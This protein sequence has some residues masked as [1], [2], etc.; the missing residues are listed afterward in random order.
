MGKVAVVKT[1]PSNVLDDYKKVMNLADYQKF[2]S[3]KNETIL[4]LNLSWSLYYPA[5]ST[6]PW[7]LEGVLRTMLEEGYKHLHAVE[8]ETVVTDVWKGAKGN[9]WLDVLKRYKQKYEPLTDKKWVHYEPKAEM[10]A[11]DEIFPEGNKIPECFIGKNVVQFPTVKCVHPETEIFM[12]DGSLVKIGEFIEALGEEKGFEKDIDGDYFINENK[13]VFSLEESKIVSYKVD[14]FWKTPSPKNLIYIK[15]KLGKEVKVS[16]KHPF[17]T[18]KGWKKSEEIQVGDRIAVPRLVKFKGRSQ[19][20]PKIEI[21]G[22]DLLDINKIKFRNGKKH[23]KELQKEIVKDY[24]VKEKTITIIGKE[25]KLNPETIRNIIKRYGFKMRWVRNWVNVPEKTSLEFWKWLGYFVAEGYAYSCSGSMRFS[26]NNGNSEVVKD[27]VSLTKNLFNVD[28]KVRKFENKL[29]ILYFDS[30]NIVSFFEELGFSFPMVAGNKFAPKILLKCPEKEIISFLEG[31]LDGDGTVGKDG[32]H[33]TSKSK[34]LIKNIQIL[35]LRLGVIGLIKETWC[36]ATNGKMKEKELYY[37]L[38]V[39]GHDLVIFGNIINLKSENKQKNLLQL[40]KRRKRSKKLTNWDTIPIDRKMF[41]KVR[42]GLDF[43][44]NT[45]KKPHSVNSIE[46]GYSLPTR[47]TMNY[48]L[49]LF[50]KTNVDQS[51]LIERERMRFLSS[52]KLAWDHIEEIKEVKSDVDWLY[53]LT[54]LGVENFIGNG[55]IL[56]NTHGH[57]Q[58]TGAMKNAFG[59]LITKKRHHCHKNIHE[60]LVDLLAIQKEIHPGRFAVMD[61]TVCGDGAGP[62]TMSPKVKNYILAS[63]D[64]VAIDAI[65]AKM[66]GYDPMKIK[67]IKLAHDRGLGMGDVDQIDI[68]GEDISKVNF[69][70]STSKSP[71]IFWDQMFRKGALSFVEPLLFHTGLFKGPVFAS[72]FYHDKIWYPTVGKSR[73]RKFMKTDWGQLWKKY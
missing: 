57:T 63:E 36:I 55:I 56:H 24:V 60:V 73:I 25:R 31:Y 29:D 3:K 62:R 45:T 41:R 49:D 46:N 44:Q 34:E 67:F 58:M 43:S 16:K 13:E 54:V 65:S 21:I 68:V 52:E 30:N 2:L 17:L 59:G 66:M 32:L 69:N 14:R 28:L 1:N 42:E 70:F 72:A 20:L 53:D 18:P 38:S 26:W 27:F 11:L 71:V 8:N 22:H 23:S 4:K 37:K 10:L 39:Y 35:L 19:K 15:T 40:I 12:A 33:V 9:K 64:Q 47:D 48:F 5:C 7:Q 6:Q 50:D 61:G 51:Y